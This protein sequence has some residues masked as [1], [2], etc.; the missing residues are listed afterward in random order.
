MGARYVAMIVPARWYSGGKGLDEFRDEM[1]KD[2]RMKILVDY[3]DASECFP[4]VEIKGGVC[5]FCGTQ[6]IMVNVKFRD[7]STAR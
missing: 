5:I 2:K 7:I 6:N 3:P 1:M 4:G